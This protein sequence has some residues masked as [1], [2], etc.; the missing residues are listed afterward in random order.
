MT[1]LTAWI[2]AMVAL[3]GLLGGMVALYVQSR[4]RE[5]TLGERLKALTAHVDLADARSDEKWKITDV[6]VRGLEGIADSQEKR[7]L[8]VELLLQ[9]HLLR[10]KD[11]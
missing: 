6:Q 8:R 2:T 7:L 9:E 1:D 11:G 5:A 4:V 10:M 3:L